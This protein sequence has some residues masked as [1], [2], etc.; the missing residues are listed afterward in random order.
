MPFQR[1]RFI[2]FMSVSEH[3]S[4]KADV[5][6]ELRLLNLGFQAAGS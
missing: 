2:I 4:R 1:F 6:M 5:V 3:G